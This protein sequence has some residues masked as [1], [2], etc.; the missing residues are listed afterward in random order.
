MS[1]VPMLEEVGRVEVRL[2]T[3]VSVGDLVFNGRT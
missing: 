3:I 1:R 2:M